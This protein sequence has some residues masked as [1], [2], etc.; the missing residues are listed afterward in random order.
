MSEGSDEVTLPR[1]NNIS[2]L[3]DDK[4]LMRVAVISCRQ[5]NKSQTIMVL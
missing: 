4:T 3:G 1:I 5:R 2:M